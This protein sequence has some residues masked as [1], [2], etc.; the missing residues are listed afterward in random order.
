MGAR[1]LHIYYSSF[2]VPT[3]FSNAEGWA[4][5]NV[6]SKFNVHN[7]GKLKTLLYGEAVE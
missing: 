6:T 2:D 7:L 3:A 1:Y 5:S 4:Q